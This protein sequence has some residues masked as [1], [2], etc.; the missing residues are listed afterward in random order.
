MANINPISTS[1]RLTL[2]L[3]EVDGKVVEK[4]V[5]ISKLNNSISVENL[6]ALSD[7]LAELLEHPVTAVKKYETSLLVD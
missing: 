2:N 6:A 1:M 4:S 5:N 3:G 7:A